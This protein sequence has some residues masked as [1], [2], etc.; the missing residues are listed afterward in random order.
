MDYKLKYLKYKSKYLEIKNNEMIGGAKQESIKTNDNT[1][2]LLKNSKSKN[3]IKLNFPG[4]EVSQ[5]EYSEGPVGLTLIKFKRPTKVHMEIRGGW[6]GYID[7]L[8]TNEKQQISGINIA[9]G[10]LLGL[11]STTGATAESL[12]SKNYKYFSGFNGAII[13]SG[14]L[15]K[16]KIYPDKNLGRFA[17]N[18]SDKYLYNGQVGAGLSASH[19]Q[20]WSYKKLKDGSEILALVVNNAVGSV[21]KDDKLIHNPYGKKEP[22]LPMKDERKNTTII[23]VITTLELDND[24]LKQ[25]NHQLNVTIG[26]SIRPFNTFTDGDIFYTC[27]TQ[28]L[29]KKYNYWNRIEFFVECSAVL[30]EAIHNTIL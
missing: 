9:G 22:F 23:V 11:E 24:E 3:F 5:C 28:K 6:P 29:K 7:C 15:L 4:I 14:N 20:G 26:E 12:K 16:N 18:Q 17:Y 2:L 30:K 27:S 25:M 13:Y 21:Y 19:G 8:S 1:K 10:S